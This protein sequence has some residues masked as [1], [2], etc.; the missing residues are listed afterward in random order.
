MRKCKHGYGGRKN[1]PGVYLSWAD[2][3]RRVRT[4]KP[5]THPH[6]GARGITV[7]ERWKKFENFLSDMGERPAGMTLD[8]IDNDGSYEPGNCRWATTSQQNRNRRTTAI[9]GFKG[10][11]RNKKKW[12]ASISVNN[13]PVHLGTYADIH[14]AAEVYLDARQIVES[15]GDPRKAMRY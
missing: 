6:Y 7:C 11:H 14:V 15:G 10:V 2:M 4:K 1:R 12:S 5:Y 13:Y 9:S 3:L 8:R